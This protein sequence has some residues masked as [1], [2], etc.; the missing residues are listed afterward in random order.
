MKLKVVLGSLLY[1]VINSLFVIKYGSRITGDYAYLTV[2]YLLSIVLFLTLYAKINMPIKVYQYV[3]MSLVLICFIASIYLN[4]VVDGH[5]LQVDR[6]SAMD[7]GIEALLNG[8]YPYAAVD[9]L[10]GRTSNLPFLIFIGI[11]F[12]FLGSVGYL[13][14]F[15]FLV[16]AY[17][18]YRLFANF[19]DR[20]FCLLL[21]VLAPS[22]LWEVYV[23]SDLMSNFILILCF[24]TFI[25]KKIAP[26]KTKSLIVLAFL[27]T[28][29]V[30]TRLVSIIPISLALFKKWYSFPRRAKVI[31]M[32]VS[33]LTFVGAFYLCFQHVESFENFKK[34]NPFELQNRQ[35]PTLI[36]G[37]LIGIPFIY[38]F[39]IN[40]IRSL[41]KSTVV[42]LLLPVVVAF[43]MKLVQYGF[44]QSLFS[45]AFDLSYFNI[46]FPFLLIYVTMEFSTVG[47][48]PLNEVKRLN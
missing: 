45:S 18:T 24:V 48:L 34:Y 28:S 17:T 20:L 41:M 7:V 12:Y 15:C 13:Q 37:L 4:R 8:E 27:A 6:W 32:T 14:S 21:L 42:F 43:G 38:S 29:L 47:S 5:S 9:S 3:F 35:L 36:S 33:V 26:P 2:G 16:F 11:P 40:S 10:G 22:Y 44:Y 39:R 31:F 1:I 23:K 19:R 25:H 46:V 30:F